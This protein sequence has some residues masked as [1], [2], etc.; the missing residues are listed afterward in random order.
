MRRGL[1]PLLLNRVSIPQELLRQRI[2]KGEP[3]IRSGSVNSD[4]FMLGIQAVSQDY[5]ARI[6]K[7][8]ELARLSVEI[9]DGNAL[10]H[11]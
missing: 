5:S 1:N 8:A 4:R 10:A 11:P 2:D 7:L 6:V 9:M 3:H